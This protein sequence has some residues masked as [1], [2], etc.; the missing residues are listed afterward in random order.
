[1]LRST[2]NRTVS[3]ILLA[4]FAL[5]IVPPVSSF[6]S[7]VQ[8][9]A[10]SDKTSPGFRSRDHKQAVRFLFDIIIWQQFKK[11]KQSE[12]LESVNNGLLNSGNE[13]TRSIKAFQPAAGVNTLILGLNHMGRRDIIPSHRSR[14]SITRFS[15]SGSSPPVLL[16]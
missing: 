6:A 5:F 3:G 16:S 7:N 10:D 14:S 12:F 2:V 4:Y 1:M 9:S 11:T 15:R 8:I 13:S